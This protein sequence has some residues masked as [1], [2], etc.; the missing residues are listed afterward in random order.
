[1]GNLR[2]IDETGDTTVKWNANHKKEVAL[3]K[4]AFDKSM[5]KTNGMAYIV[6]S[7]GNQGKRI[8]DFDPL[9][10]NIVI[11]PGHVPGPDADSQAQIG[12]FL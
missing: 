8:Y 5:K 7:K 2:I 1:M 6:D 10:E 3:A 12:D 11:V 9:A 4:D